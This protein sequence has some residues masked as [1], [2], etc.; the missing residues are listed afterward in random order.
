M[1]IVKSEEGV[2]EDYQKRIEAELQK[3]TDELIS[4]SDDVCKK[5]I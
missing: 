2:S 1:D 5:R 3:V 4:M